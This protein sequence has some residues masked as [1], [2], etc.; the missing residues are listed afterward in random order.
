MYK[1]EDLDEARQELKRWRDRFDNYDGN[2]PNK[3]QSE[4]RA[5]RMKVRDIEASLKAQGFL[6]MSEQETL[7]AELDKHFPTA[8]SKEIVE[9]G[10]KRY[11]R[12]FYPAERSNSG[13]SVTQWHKSW[14]EV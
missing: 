4:I 7:E 13:K 14:K 6:P 8:Q 5:A 10:G 3:Y 9:H 11:E 1:L 12:R 2:N